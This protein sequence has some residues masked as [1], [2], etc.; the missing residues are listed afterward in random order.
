[1]INLNISFCSLRTFACEQ[2]SHSKY[3]GNFGRCS[4]ANVRFRNISNNIEFLKET[5]T[6]SE[7]ENYKKRLNLPTRNIKIRKN[8]WMIILEFALSRP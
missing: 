3:F 1:M 2:C 8:P 6:K 4:L 7:T 5:S